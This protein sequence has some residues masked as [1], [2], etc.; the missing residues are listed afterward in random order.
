MSDWDYHLY[1][2]DSQ[3]TYMYNTMDATADDFR[4]LA[5]SLTGEG[6]PT[7]GSVAYL[8]ELKFNSF[9]QKWGG[10]SSTIVGRIKGCLNHLEGEMGGGEVDMASILTALLAATPDEIAQF[11]GIVDAFRVSIWNRPY[12]EEFYAALARGFTQW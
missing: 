5:A 10:G 3:S 8:L 2:L 12:N 1:Q 6:N 7:S 9:R 11:I 4:D